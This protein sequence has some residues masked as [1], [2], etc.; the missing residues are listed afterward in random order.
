MALTTRA[1]SIVVPIVVITMATASITKALTEQ[2][3]LKD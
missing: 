2:G 1:T 3:L